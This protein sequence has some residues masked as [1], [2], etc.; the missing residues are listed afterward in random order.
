MLHNCK[1]IVFKVTPYNDKSQVVQ[2][3]TEFFGIQS[4]MVHISTSKKSKNKA[5]YF[6]PLT[7]LDVVISHKEKE[8][9]NSLKELSVNYIYQHIP[10]SIEKQTVLLFINEV[11][12]KC[13]KESQQNTELFHFIFESLILFDK[14]KEGVNNFHIYFLLKLS[15]YLGFEPHGKHTTQTPFFDLK[16]GKFASTQPKHPIYLS[17]TESLIFYSFLLADSHHLT[18]LTFSNEARKNILSKVIEYYELHIDYFKNLKS[19][20]VLQEV[21]E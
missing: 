6:Q 20:A 15:S 10:T 16:E 9:L 1:A 21:F 8:G 14:L 19:I 4:Y 2:L 13:I 7:L 5:A 11:L 17:S 18:E 3:Y 12:F